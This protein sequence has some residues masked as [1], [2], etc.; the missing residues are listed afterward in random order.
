MDDVSTRPAYISHRQSRSH[1]AK[2]GPGCGRSTDGLLARVE[3]GLKF[4]DQIRL[5]VT[6]EA[7]EPM[8][9]VQHVLDN[10]LDH[11]AARA[12]PTPRSANAIGDQ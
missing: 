2:L 8:H 7:K 11:E 9:R 1:P 4:F 10:G 5:L 3:G 12:C 6:V